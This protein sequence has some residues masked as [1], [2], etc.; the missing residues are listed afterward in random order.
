MKL[1]RNPT[2]YNRAALGSPTHSRL[3]EFQAWETLQRPFNLKMPCGKGASF[4]ASNQKFPKSRPFERAPSKGLALGY[5]SLN[6]WLLPFMGLKREEIRDKWLH[7]LLFSAFAF[8]S[9]QQ[10]RSGDG[11]GLEEKYG[12]FSNFVLQLLRGAQLVHK[13]L[14]IHWVWEI[15]LSETMRLGC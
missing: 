2:I 9:N 14:F 4:F 15:W 3:I 11:L 1:K 10:Q 12:C 5:S 7:F 8:S 6:L 13:R